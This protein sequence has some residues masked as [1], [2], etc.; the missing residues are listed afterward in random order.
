[1][2]NV[3]ILLRKYKQVSTDSR[4]KRH[5]QLLY[6]LKLQEKSN[7]GVTRRRVHQALI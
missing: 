1:M 7:N 5:N 6:I 3:E 4:D 2:V